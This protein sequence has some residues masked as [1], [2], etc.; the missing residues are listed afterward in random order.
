M[1]YHPLT[2]A[3]LPL[4]FSTLGCPDWPWRRVLD[5]AVRLGYAGIEL[6]GLDGE[7]EL[8]RRAEFSAARIADTRREL[9]SREL[10]ISDLGA[11][12]RLHE[13]DPRIREAQL[14]DA[15]RYID[16]AHRLGAP[17]VR[18]FPDRAVTGEPREAT[19]A[20]IG[21]GLAELARFARG[22]GVGVLVES[23]GDFTDGASL[24]AIMKAAREAPGAG[25]LWDTHHTVMTGRER[26][27]DTWPLIGRNVHHTH[28]KDSKRQGDGVRYVLTGEGDVDVRHVVGVLKRAGYTGF[29]GLEWE[30][31]WHPDLP[32]PEVAFPQFVEVM[33][34]YLAVPA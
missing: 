31:R 2:V 6:R 25:L 22:S 10:V 32:G 26:P 23:H 18:V 13:P 19:I 1:D 3:R 34:E 24:A 27:E 14:D 7:M 30:K 4:T 9:A 12:T 11:S 15:R 17:W 20:R 5:E 21:A 16:L 29:Y 33:R 28:L 8:T